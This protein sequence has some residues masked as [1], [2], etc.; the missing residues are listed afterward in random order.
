MELWKEGVK[1]LKYNNF[2]IIYGLLFLIYIINI[3]FDSSVIHLVISWSAVVTLVMSS[4]RATNLFRL[5]GLIFSCAGV[6]MSQTHQPKRS[7][8]HTSE[9]QSRFYL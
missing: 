8:E 5:M 3:L 1:H 7:E 4:F 2:Y 6:Y 9:L